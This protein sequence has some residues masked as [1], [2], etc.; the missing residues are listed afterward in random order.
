MST[1]C[2]TEPLTFHGVAGPQ[3]VARCDGGALTSNGGAVLLR[4]VDRATGAPDAMHGVLHGSSGSRARHAHGGVA[5]AAA[6]VRLGARVRGL[7]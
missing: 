1:V 7:A 6:R 3:V 5:R 2:T 4:E